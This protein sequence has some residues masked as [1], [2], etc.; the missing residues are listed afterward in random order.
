MLPLNESTTARVDLRRGD[1]QHAIDAPG[2][3]SQAPV[4]L[5]IVDDHRMF[6]DCLARLLSDESSLDVLAVTD[7]TNAVQVCARLEPSVALVDYQMPDRS[8]AQ[9]AADIREQAPHTAVVMLTSF[10]DDRILFEAID[11][12]CAGLLTKD[13]PADEVIRAVHAAANGEAL[14]SPSQLALLRDRFTRRSHTLGDDLTEREREVL[15]L[16]ARGWS[17]KS[18]ATHLHLTVNTIRNYVQ[19][20]ITKLGAH[21]KLEA[22]STAVREGIIDLADGG[23]P[24]RAG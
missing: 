2:T 14:V 6:A 16:M 11:A 3:P 17:T 10:G 9:V 12:G 19:S 1:D 21:S 4:R 24:S 8:G 5:V 15:T 13:R 22:V 7:G 18:V 20:V 23:D